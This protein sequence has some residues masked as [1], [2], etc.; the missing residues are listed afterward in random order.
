MGTQGFLCQHQSLSYFLLVFLPFLPQCFLLLFYAVTEGK[1]DR[2][3]ISGLV[4]ALDFGRLEMFNYC[5]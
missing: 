2:G 5:F 4:K 3:Q 1:I